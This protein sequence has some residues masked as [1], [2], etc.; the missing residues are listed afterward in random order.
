MRRIRGVRRLSTAVLLMALTVGLAASAGAF[1][2]SRHTG[3]VVA[4]SRLGL[5][6]SATYLLALGDSLASGYQPTD[7]RAPPP[8]DKE[9]GYPDEGYPDGYTRDLAR[10]EHLRLVDL[11][12]PG[13]T[14]ASMTSTP[15]TAGCG[16]VYRKEFSTSSQLAAALRFLADHRHEV[17]LV[18]IDIGANDIEHCVSG[19]VPSS[20]CLREGATS[21]ARQLPAILARLRRAL[22][23][24]DP[25]AA[26]IGMNYYDP[27][28][29]L[30]FRPG[31]VV[32]S[33]EAFLSLALVE[34]YNGELALA[35]ASEHVR[36]AD[37]AAALASSST[38]PR[39]SY[40]GH[41]LP[42][43]VAM[44]CRLTWM[45]PPSGKPASAADIHPNTIGY[46]LI[47]HA[48]EKVLNGS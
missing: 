2:S 17:R 32:A 19:G 34:T 23:V 22:E 39:Q 20:S 7:G 1:R 41:K 18:T 25:H 35:Y 13:E 38:T 43:N 31:T 14:T 27:F 48:F 45:C 3:A 16:T 42:R 5:D 36:V 11:A 40:G 24:D 37:V 21:I 44:I 28:L 4:A 26:L 9:A 15:A 30:A 6:R 10:A 8:I 46:R 47:A 12:C 29:A 33:A